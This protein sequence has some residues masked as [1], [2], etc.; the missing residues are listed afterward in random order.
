MSITVVGHVRRSDLEGGHW[1][2]HSDA[3]VI[4]QLKGGR[5]DL[6]RDGVKAEVKGRL[7]TESMGLAMLGEILEVRS[8]RILD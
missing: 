1:M 5:G 8:F 3:G 4:Y 2:L 6:L 7:A